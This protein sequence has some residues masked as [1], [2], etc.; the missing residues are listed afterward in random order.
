MF[1]LQI[2]TKGRLKAETQKKKKKR[3][4]EESVMSHKV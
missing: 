1:V 4:P 2:I 3:K